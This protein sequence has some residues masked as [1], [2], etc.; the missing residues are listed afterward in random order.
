MGNLTKSIF[1][2]RNFQSFK[3]INVL[4]W[5]I[6]KGFLGN[7]KADSKCQTHFWLRRIGPCPF[8][9]TTGPLGPLTLVFLPSHFHVVWCSRTKSTNCLNFDSM[10]PLITLKVT[11]LVFKSLYPN[12]PQ[13]K[14]SN[15]GIKV[16][17]IIY[18]I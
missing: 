4:C 7:Q 16:S 1:H 15:I 2:Q 12:W 13:D 8:H 9:S 3:T 11:K 10:G 5:M 14:V 6:R 18:I 17:N